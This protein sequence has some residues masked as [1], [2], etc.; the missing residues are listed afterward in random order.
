M[1]F[2][3]R[4]MSFLL[5]PCH[6]LLAAICSLVSHREQQIVDFQNVQ[7]EDLLK[8]PGTKQLSSVPISRL[9]SPTLDCQ[10][11]FLS[12]RYLASRGSGSV[13]SSCSPNFSTLRGCQ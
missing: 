9:D 8:K 11:A 12:A 2:S 4:K 1:G 10:S 7:I 5:Q 6:V 3:T 13:S